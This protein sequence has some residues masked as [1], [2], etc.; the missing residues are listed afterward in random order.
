[1]SSLLLARAKRLRHRP[2][3]R[4][5]LVVGLAAITGLFAARVVDSAR[6]ARTRWGAGHP[7]VVMV[8]AVAAGDRIEATEVEVR[9]LPAA[10]LPTTAVTD[11]PI[12]RVATSDLY[13][14]EVLVEERVAP[15]GVQGAAA[16]LPPG[17]RALAVPS[18]PGTPPLLVGDTVD[19]LATY[20]PF[21]F[22]P[23]AA[24]T[25]AG[26]AG[27][28]VVSGATVIDVSEGAVTVAVDPDDAP[29]VAFALSQGAVTLALA[30]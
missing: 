18:G 10:L 12:G 27:E 29:E 5:L 20:D 1:M 6:S 4:W 25:P 22:D 13:P 2:A 30:G 8:E 28:M 26:G 7:V 19:L 3:L 24:T 16:L 11:P 14:G 15:E 21:L 9:S 23:A 17:S